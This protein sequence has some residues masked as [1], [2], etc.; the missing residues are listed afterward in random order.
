MRH[1]NE[2]GENHGLAT[3]GIPPVRFECSRS[4][5]KPA[6]VVIAVVLCLIACSCRHLDA[7]P[8]GREVDRAAL[9]DALLYHIR[10]G[11]SVEGMAAGEGKSQLTCLSEELQAS[12]VIAVLA[13]FDV[14][15]ERMLRHGQVLMYYKWSDFDEWKN[16][17]EVLLN[18]LGV[19]PELSG[20]KVLVLSCSGGISGTEDQDR[21][22]ADIVYGSVNWSRSKPAMNWDSDNLG[23]HLFRDTD[24]KPRLALFAVSGS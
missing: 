15:K 6:T 16:V 1:C 23:F 3:E 7:A 11:W 19:R 14:P 2:A 5:Q 10:A 17:Q 21:L 13:N 12:D 9:G 4:K 18:E 8:V 22:G 20:A 24:G